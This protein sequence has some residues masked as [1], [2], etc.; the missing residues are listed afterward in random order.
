MG[1]WLPASHHQRQV[2]QAASRLHRS[3]HGTHC[4]SRKSC[5]STRIVLLVESRLLLLACRMVLRLGLLDLAEP[6]CPWLLS[7]NH[8]EHKLQTSNTT[9]LLHTPL[10]L[11]AFHYTIYSQWSLNI[12]ASAVCSTETLMQYFRVINYSTSRNL[13]ACSRESG[14]IVSLYSN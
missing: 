13:V 3:M 9:H 12:L 8:Q 10:T 11:Y 14:F 2:S 4:I 7:L 6:F 1:V 5:V